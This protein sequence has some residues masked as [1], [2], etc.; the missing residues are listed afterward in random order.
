MKNNYSKIIFLNLIIVIL[1]YSFFSDDTD[2]SLRGIIFLGF[3]SSFFFKENLLGNFLKLMFVNSF[4]FFLL[5]I[6]VDYLDWVIMD[7]MGKGNPDSLA[8]ILGSVG[9]S[10]GLTH[11]YMFGYFTG[12]I[13]KAILERFRK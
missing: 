5:F 10:F 1:V 3:A 8:S 11:V 7:I 9:F 4:F 12:I 2:V 13:P 6:P